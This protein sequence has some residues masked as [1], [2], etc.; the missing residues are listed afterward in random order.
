MNRRKFL[1]RSCGVLIVG[2]SAG[3]ILAQNVQSVVKYKVIEQRCNGCGLCYKVC[4]DQALTPVQDKAF[5]DH[6]KCTGCGD[7]LRF[8]R[9]MAIVE[10]DTV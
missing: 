5:I 8:C 10:S 2:V 9:R 6:N 1:L 4:K 7:C 3:N